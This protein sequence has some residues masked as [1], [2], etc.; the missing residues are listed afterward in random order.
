LSIQKSYAAYKDSPL[1]DCLLSSISFCT[2]SFSNASESQSASTS[3]E[4]FSFLQVSDGFV[5]YEQK[6]ADPY[7]RLKWFKAVDAVLGLLACIVD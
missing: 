1:N 4:V 7:F 2:V 3:F 6:Q 5:S